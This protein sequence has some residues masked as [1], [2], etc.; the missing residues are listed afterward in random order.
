VKL[1][2]KRPSALRVRG[3]GSANAD[4]PKGAGTIP[5]GLRRFSMEPAGSVQFWARRGRPLG[6]RLRAPGTLLPRH[7]RKRAPAELR[8]CRACSEPGRASPSRARNPPRRP[9]DPDADAGSRMA[10]RQ[11]RRTRDRRAVDPE[12]DAAASEGHRL[13][14]EP[15]RCGCNHRTRRRASGN[16][17]DS[18]RA[19]GRLAFPGAGAAGQ[20][21]RRRLARPARR[22][23]RA[24]RRPRCRGA[25]RRVGPRAGVLHLRNDRS[26]ESRAPHPRLH[27]RATRNLDAMAWGTHRGTA[28][29]HQ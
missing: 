20:R 2:R 22:R 11:R 1:T 29:D 24:A 13:P 4:A 19:A 23:R 8:R 25:N 7:R 17:C 10:D 21:R 5:A 27:L 15:Q 28:V 26:A 3:V 14:C 12:F 6:G 9:A 18:S 16:G